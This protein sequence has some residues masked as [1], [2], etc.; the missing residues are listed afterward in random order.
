MILKLSQYSKYL[1]LF[2]LVFWSC[3]EQ[4]K[5]G[6]LDS[7]ACNYDSDATIN[8]NSCLYL[9]CKDECGG[10]ALVDSCGTCDDDLSNDCIED[11][12]GVFGGS[13]Y[14]DNCG[15]CDN[16]PSNDCTEDCAGEWGGQNICGCTDITATNYNSD[17]TFDD[18]SC[19]YNM[20]DTITIQWVKTYEGV[21]DESWRVRQTFDSGFIIAG[22]SN[23]SGLLIKTNQ[24]GD[25]EWSQVY[26]NSTALY[27]VRETSDGG[28]FAVGFYEC[29]TLPG[30]YPDLYLL[31]TDESG[32][33]I[34][35]LIDSG[36]E[37]ND[38]ARDFIETADG[39]YVV[40]GTWNDNGNNS[41]A[42]LRKY[43]NTGE[44]IWHEIYSSSA[45]NE[46]NEII[47]TADGNYVLGGYT[48]TQ[49]GD[50]K[51]L[52]IKTDMDGQQIWKKN[53]QSTGSTEIYAL[54][55][56]PG[57]SY[58]GAG[59][60]N[61]W[62]SLYL[63]ER[64]TSGGGV[65]NDCNIVD[66]NVSGYYDIIPSSR[67]GYYLIDAGSNLT[68][69]NDQG[70]TIFREYVGYANMSIFELENG[71]IIIGGYGFIDGN[72]GGIISLVRLTPPIN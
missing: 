52:M 49:H 53:I 20:S 22:A 60:C 63:V 59:Y 70:E 46:I 21:G 26:D 40:T 43:S 30:C 7:Q 36:T 58:I 35:E 17:A 15:V 64:N 24:N 3:E 13:A 61:S 27:S 31:K 33:I 28:F 1:L 2:G 25:L 50:Y 19:Q 47:E 12:S 54:N 65:F 67:G 56:T 9:D 45:A 66:V 57:G 42:M 41:K 44:L 39:E 10:S 32:N 71:D 29:D 72:S 37:N 48:G 4:E 23:Y 55:E 5:H 34:W 16:N 6:C 14:I 11:C 69:I 38:W 62:R 68:W 8:N 51:A 18:G